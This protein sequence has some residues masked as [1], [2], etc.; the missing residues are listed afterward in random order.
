MIPSHKLHLLALALAGVLTA[1]HSTAQVGTLPAT[2]R[3]NA[4]LVLVP[5]SVIDHS[6]KT[7][8][9]LTARNFTLMEDQVS[10]QIVSFTSDDA[11][12]SVGIV[13]DISGSMR[14]TLTGAK[15][16][17]HVFLKTANP[18]DEFFLLTVSSQPDALSGFTTD[19]PALEREVDSTRP[20]GM[21]ALI[22]TVYAALNQMRK[23]HKSR[24]ALII[25]SD[26]LDNNSR[27]SKNELMRV[28][29]EADVQV[30]TVLV[31]NDPGGGSAGGALFRPS[32]AAKPWDQAR[33]LQGPSMLEE[34]SEKTGGLHFHARNE[35]AAKE[36][37]VKV[38]R[39]IREEYVIGYH[40]AEAS[41]SGKWHR[42]RVKADVPHV[43][44]YAR[45][46]YY[47]R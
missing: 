26:G 14:Y 10:Q 24:R 43:S 39:A 3:T 42:V 4:Q 20:G 40:P 29:L 41:S 37:A 44:V 27:Y 36:A 17:A 9:G 45:N 46:G 23:A 6:G 22:D 32:M 35:D 8:E 21:T 2:F 13:L 25:V 34:L 15:A 19:V 1:S 31:N 33:Q 7:V 16:I 18:E 30:Y 5:V 28:A 11:P 47:S 38:G 12:S